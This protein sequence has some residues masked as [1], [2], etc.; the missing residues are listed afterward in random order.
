MAEV[1]VEPVLNGSWISKE[2]EKYLKQNIFY[3][4]VCMGLYT[5]VYKRI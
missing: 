4:Y 2:R 5:Y 1:E 3:V